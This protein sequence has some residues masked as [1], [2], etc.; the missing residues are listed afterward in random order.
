MVY[1]V[2]AFFA[3]LFIGVMGIAI[4]MLYKLLR[5]IINGI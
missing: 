2:V 1:L 4:A 3:I 5:G